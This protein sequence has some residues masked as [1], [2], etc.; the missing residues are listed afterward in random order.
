MFRFVG[1]EPEAQD[2][3][4][5]KSSVHFRAD[6]DPIAETILVCTAPGPMPISPAALPFRHLAPGIRLEPGGPPFIPPA[7]G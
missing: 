1:I 2:I 6:F 3:L 7:Q 5:V 4:V